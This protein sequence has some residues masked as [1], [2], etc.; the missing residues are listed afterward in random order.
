ISSD[1]KQIAEISSVIDDIAFQTNLLALNAA[2]EAARAGE[3]GKGFA[4]V[5]DAVRSLA[6][7]SADSAKNI[8]SLIED[9]V[10]RIDKGATQA[11]HSGEV[12]NEIVN[13]IKKVSDLNHEIATASEE[14]SVG[15]TQISRAMNQLDVVTQENAA[16]SQDSATT[17]EELSAQSAMLLKSV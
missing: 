8:N 7:R 10:D 5:A 17:A 2:V 4:V 11:N 15:I 14:Q 13:S 9:S 3:Q 12:L 6:Q 1:S 16:A